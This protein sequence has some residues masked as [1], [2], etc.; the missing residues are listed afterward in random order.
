MN[1]QKVPFVLMNSSRMPKL[2]AKYSYDRSTDLKVYNCSN[3]YQN[4]SRCLHTFARNNNKAIHI[5]L[6]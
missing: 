6:K 4:I 2:L 5:L 1:R 3:E